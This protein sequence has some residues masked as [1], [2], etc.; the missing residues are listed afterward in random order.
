MYS[1]DYKQRAVAFKD[2]GHTFK[3]FKE[4]FNIPPETYY[5]WKEKLENGYYDKKIIRERKRKIDKNELKQALI[6]KPDAYL[7]ELAEQCGCTATAVF[8]ALKELT[9]TRKKRPLPIE[10]S[11]KSN[12]KSIR[13]G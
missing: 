13:I 3:E 2:E 5:L 4:A 6:E 8:Y 11:P 7:W 12:V 9:I 1:I 10:K